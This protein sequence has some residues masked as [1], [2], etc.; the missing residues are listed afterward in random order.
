MQSRPAAFHVVAG[1]LT[2]ATLDLIYACSFWAWLRHVSPMRL[3]QY[4]AS[5]ALGKAAFEGGIG[6]ALIGA[7]FH[8][9][10]AIV[11]V[12]VYFL[13]SRR[14]RV[15]VRYPVRYGVAVRTTGLGRDD[16][17][18]GAAVAG[19][20]L[21][22]AADAGLRDQLTHAP[23]VRGD[24]RMVLATRARAARL[25]AIGPIGMRRTGAVRHPLPGL[26]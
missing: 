14:Y 8:Y 11:M 21:G 15:L 18:R 16:L 23:A 22:E 12:L 25:S 7:G 10:I 6:T 20:N 2:L 13:A 26:A 17:R 5:G 3:L 4:I 19:A 24:L 1:G 9:S